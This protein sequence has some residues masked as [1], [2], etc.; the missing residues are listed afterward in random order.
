MEAAPYDNVE[1]PVRKPGTGTWPGP[2]QNAAPLSASSMK[3]VHVQQTTIK[4]SRTGTKLAPLLEG[5]ES[6]ESEDQRMQAKV[7]HSSQ[8]GP[9]SLVRS[10]ILFLKVTL[11]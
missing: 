9:H 5:M 1:F 11:V 8:L 6:A 4:D 7:V 2:G 10:I 3:T